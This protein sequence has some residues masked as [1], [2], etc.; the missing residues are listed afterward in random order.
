MQ[1]SECVSVHVRNDEYTNIKH[2]KPIVKGIHPIPLKNQD[3]HTLIL[4]AETRHT[5]I[6]PSHSNRG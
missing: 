6:Y 5:E 3:K 4:F 1:Y 2:Q